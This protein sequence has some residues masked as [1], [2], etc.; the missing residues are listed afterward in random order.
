[1]RQRKWHINLGRNRFARPEDWQIYDEGFPGQGEMRRECAIPTLWRTHLTDAV[2]FLPGGTLIST[3]E[4]L[5][6]TSSSAEA[7]FVRRPSTLMS[8]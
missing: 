8:L 4:Y 6:P 2:I 3:N 1:M 5:S 7:A